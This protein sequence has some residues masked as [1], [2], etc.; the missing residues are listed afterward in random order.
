MTAKCRKGKKDGKI[1]PRVV[2]L[3]AFEMCT[4]NIV[5]NIITILTIFGQNT[6][7]FD[8]NQILLAMICIYLSE[9]GLKSHILG[10]KKKYVC[11]R[12]DDRP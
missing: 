1:I 5:Y 2:S 3:K 8:D 7:E 10:Q 6:A 12:S 4:K 11:L 9:F